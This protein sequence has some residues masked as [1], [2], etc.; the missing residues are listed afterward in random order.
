MKFK[1]LFLLFFLFPTL[2]F[3]LNEKECNKKFDEINAA[4]KTAEDRFDKFNACDRQ[5]QIDK[6]IEHLRVAIPNYN[7]VIK[8]YGEIQ[9]GINGKKAEG[10]RKA[11]NDKCNN[12]KLP[13]IKRLIE[14]TDHLAAT[15]FD[16]C[17]DSVNMANSKIQ[18][19]QQRTNLEDIVKTYNEAAQL[20]ENAAKLAQEAHD[21]VPS[22]DNMIWLK[23]VHDQGRN[24]DRAY[25]KGKVQEYTSS[26]AYWRNE[27]K[28]LPLLAQST[29]K[30]NAAHQKEQEHPRLLNNVDAVVN[31]LNEAARLY[32]EAAT[33]ARAAFD[34]TASTPL[35]DHK[36]QLQK[37]IQDYEAG[38]K[39]CREEAA[40]LPQTVVGIKENLRARI[41]TLKSESVTWEEKG[42][43][44]NALDAQIQMK[45]LLEQLIASNP[46][47]EKEAAA[48]LS[49]LE[50]SIPKLTAHID[51]LR[52][53]AAAPQLT[54]EMFEAQESE[55]QNRFY[56]SDVLL[57]P[58]FPYELYLGS[59]RNVTTHYIKAI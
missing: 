36:A 24:S 14:L 29:D 41:S 10:W 51:S 8:L 31:S 30:V 16:K 13:A 33:A 56:S 58:E 26:A 15:I 40:N 52:L 3:A 38:A 59:P 2:L 37:N 28:A 35:A 47:G 4:K 46:E 57:Y 22:G 54:E 25:L 20:Y 11:A 1:H 42:F 7:K 39:R 49:L 48:E 44:R 6:R 34:I 9:D 17:C 21:T 23:G 18:A 27:A 12:E 19:S 45:S 5:T 50:L 55:R 53:T 43:I 32:E